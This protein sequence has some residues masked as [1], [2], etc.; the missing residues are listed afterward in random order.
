[1]PE[2]S[3][4][5]CWQSEAAKWHR[6]VGFGCRPRCAPACGLR[7][8]LRCSPSLPL[9][10]R[11]GG[12]LELSGFFGGRLSLARSSAFS[13][14]SAAFSASKI[15]NRAVKSFRRSNNARISASVPAL[16]RRAKS[17]GRVIH[18]LTHVRSRKARLFLIIESIC[19]TFLWI[20]APQRAGRPE[21]LP[22]LSLLV[23]GRVV[24]H[25]VG[26]RGVER[27]T[28]RGRF[29]EG[30][31][32][33]GGCRAD[34]VGSCTQPSRSYRRISDNYGFYR[35]TRISVRID[36]QMARPILCSQRF[37]WQS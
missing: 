11:D 36:W 14:R 23:P 28:S 33:L 2:T 24:V 35:T 15:S 19:R 21:Q 9:C 5:Q 4:L 17:G 18:R 25:E 16:S 10:P 30:R 6:L 29:Q 1:M 12:V 3:A 31:V 7:F 20:H 22:S 8:G 34:R 37:W 13:A 27:R 26:S 32:S